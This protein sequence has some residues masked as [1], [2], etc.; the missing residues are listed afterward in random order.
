M[1][2]RWGWDV[3]T[4]DSL[5]VDR[6][7][8]SGWDVDPNHYA[9][10]PNPPGPMVRQQGGRLVRSDQKVMTRQQGGRLVRQEGRP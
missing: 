10:S 1:P 7:T 2:A 8:G 6:Q 5:P 9:P 3:A 4:W